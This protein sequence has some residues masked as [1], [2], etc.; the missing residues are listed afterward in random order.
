MI[1]SPA[2]SISTLPT[3]VASQDETPT[4]RFTNR[5]TFSR[6]LVVSPETFSSSQIDK[7]RRHGIRLRRYHAETGILFITI[8]TQLHAQL[9]L[10]LYDLYFVQ[11][12]HI[13]LTRS[14]ISIGSTTFRSQGHPGG[15]GDGGK[16]GGESDSPGRPKPGRTGINDWPTLVIEAGDSEPLRRLRDDMEWWFSA[17]D[18][19]VKIV[20]LAKF[21]HQ[22]RKIILEKWEEELPSR[23]GATMTRQAAALRPVL[24]QSITIIQNTATNPVSYNVS[25]GALVLP[26]RLL[27]L[28]DPVGPQERDFIIS[29]PDLEYYANEVWRCVR[30]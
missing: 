2:L 25:S 26:F 12:V 9:H 4:V 7:G 16:D 29:V 17:S 18:H 13:G 28:R 6:L 21:D 24:R 5:V 8:P 14:W 3:S 19:Q 20:L 10:Q 15:D 30:D 23:P 22:H 27:F 11:L 1:K